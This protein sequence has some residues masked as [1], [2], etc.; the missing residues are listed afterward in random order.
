MPDRFHLH[1]APPA[2]RNYTF[3]VFR[4]A[5]MEEAQGI[6]R[7]IREYLSLATRSRKTVHL[8]LKYDTSWYVMGQL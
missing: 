2:G 5:E 6:L 1:M 8:T 4:E 7:Q 3:Y